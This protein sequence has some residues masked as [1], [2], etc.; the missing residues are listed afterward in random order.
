MLVVII[1]SSCGNNLIMTSTSTVTINSQVFIVPNVKYLQG[2]YVAYKFY[3]DCLNELSDDD[4]ITYPQLEISGE[5]CINFEEPCNLYGPYEPTEDLSE[6]PK[7]KFA[8]YLLEVTDCI[9]DMEED[10][11]RYFSEISLENYDVIL[12]F[13]DL[14]FY[15][16]FLVFTEYT[17]NK[18]ITMT[19]TRPL[20]YENMVYV[21]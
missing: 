12:G 11:H 3:Y 21:D 9:Y 2:I 16:G 13:D 5:H 19:V 18:D 20:D 10:P 7:E 15:H 4:L 14:D 17:N 8:N 6:I 1:I